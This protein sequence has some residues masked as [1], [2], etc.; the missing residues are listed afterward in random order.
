MEEEEINDIQTLDQI[1]P[2]TIYL[3]FPNGN[4]DDQKVPEL[5]PVNNTSS[6]INRVQQKTGRHK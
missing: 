3:S 6:W 2:D 1:V 5:Q 4:P